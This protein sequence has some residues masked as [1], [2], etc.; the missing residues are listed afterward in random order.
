MTRL[1]RVF[2]RPGLYVVYGRPGSFK[3]AFT[4]WASSIIRGERL[5]LGVAKHSL[6]CGRV[7]YCKPISNVADLLS[8]LLENLDAPPRVMAVDGVEALLIPLWSANRRAAMQL[9][10]FVVETLL[11]ASRGGCTC[12]LTME[13]GERPHFYSTLRRVDGVVMLRLSARE[14]LVVDVLGRDLEPLS[15]HRIPLEEMLGVYDERGQG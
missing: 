8:A 14:E 5:Y 6:L 15:R 12:L 4:L 10:L 11:R 1:N 9:L 3:T 7:E 13:G 2:R